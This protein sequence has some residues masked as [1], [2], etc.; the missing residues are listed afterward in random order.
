MKKYLIIAVLVAMII[1]LM[2]V[3]GAAAGDN[4]TQIGGPFKTQDAVLITVCEDLELEY[5]DSIPSIMIDTKGY[6]KFKL[7]AYMTP[8]TGVNQ[9]YMRIMLH[10]AATLDSEKALYLS[11]S[12]NPVTDWI[13][14]SSTT[15]PHYS[16]VIPIQDGIYSVFRV[17]GR[18]QWM[19][20]VGPP[21]PAPGTQPPVSVSV[22]LLMA[23]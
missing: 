3:T 16:M 8:Y 23:K 10:E 5:G 17:G 7:Y 2:S 11:R 19:P 12:P 14:W 6:N 9:S 20:S 1:G 15:I 4:N 13:K 22:Y 21:S 18:Y